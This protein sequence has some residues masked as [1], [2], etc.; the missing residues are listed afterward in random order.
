MEQP[1]QCKYCNAR[2]HRESTLSTHMCVKK[3][4]FDDSNATGPRLG[5]RTYQRYYTQVMRTKKLKTLDEFIDSEFYTDFV[6]FGNHLAM[7]KPIHHDKYVDFVIMSG[8]KLKEWTSDLL[9]RAYII[10]LVRSEPAVSATERSITNI[11]EWSTE[12]SS[13]FNTFFS[14]ISPNEAAYMISVGKISPWV[15]YLSENG[16]SLIGKF[17]E[18][19]SK[20]IGD[21]IDPG[22]WMKKFK[23]NSE[24][25]EYI[26]D[27]L[28]QTGL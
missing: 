18:D 10:D 27:L 5:F 2:F 28:S 4:R 17:N 15:L 6:R 24:D 11:V 19:H 23:K 25:V 13:A 26:R 7:L 12:N 20:M 21:I 22:V 16:G 14:D 9:Y 8:A 3:R 1:Y